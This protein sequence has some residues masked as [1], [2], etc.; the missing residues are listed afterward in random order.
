MRLSRVFLTAVVLALG[1]IAIFELWPRNGSSFLPAPVLR[2]MRHEIRVDPYSSLSYSALE[3]RA[4][5]ALR[6]TSA[7]VASL[8]MNGGLIISD[9][10]RAAFDSLTSLAD[11]E[12]LA[13]AY[14]IKSDE[15][16]LFKAKAYLVQWAKTFIPVSQPIQQ[17]HLDSLIIAYG[18]LREKL[19]LGERAPL[20]DFFRR[21]YQ[22]GESWKTQLD[23]QGLRHRLS[24]NWNSH[25]IKTSV[26]IGYALND[27]QI[28]MRSIKEYKKH[29]AGNLR[30]DGS[31]YDL[32]QR[33]ALTYHLYNLG[34][35]LKTAVYAAAHGEDLY[36]YRATNGASLALAIRYIL[37]F[38]QGFQTHIEFMR[39]TS[40]NDRVRGEAGVLP[41][42][43]A[44]NCAADGWRVLK[45]ASVFDRSLEA[46]VE[47]PN[48]YWVY[49]VAKSTVIEVR[50]IG[51][52]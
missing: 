47:A 39:S 4:E 26:L 46:I 2:E 11:I 8:D 19:S 41:L 25:R 12:A 13:F 30:P 14:T 23:E 24:T 1:V 34:A 51:Q 45:V 36:N 48:P 7:A 52:Y 10:H 17:S 21:V 33:D 42:G 44:W 40:P 28:K 37:P 16:Y 32:E 5:R 38:C 3:R 6:R 50:G 29:I 31:S 20:D 35:L 9:E 15:R 27:P 18:L 43:K 49:V 22:A